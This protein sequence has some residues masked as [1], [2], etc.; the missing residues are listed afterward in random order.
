[1][2]SNFERD[3]LVPACRNKSSVFKIA[4]VL[5]AFDV[6]ISF[7][8]TVVFSAVKE[9]CYLVSQNC[10]LIPSAGLEREGILLHS[11]NAYHHPD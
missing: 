6:N 11:S 10:I 7:S 3:P 4:L 2:T 8:P 1:M 5:L 9:A